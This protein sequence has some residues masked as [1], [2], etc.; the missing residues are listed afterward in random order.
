MIEERDGE[1]ERERRKLL[2]FSAFE[3]LEKEVSQ[4]NQVIEY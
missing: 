4:V 3:V 2:F 1:R